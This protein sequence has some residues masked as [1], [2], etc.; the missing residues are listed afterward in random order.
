[1]LGLHLGRSSRQRAYMIS[2]RQ[3]KRNTASKGIRNARHLNASPQEAIRIL[4][5]L[6]IQANNVGINDLL[7]QLFKHVADGEEC[8]S[9]EKAALVL[10]LY[11]RAR[12]K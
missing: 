2:R 11:P 5:G 1:M 8:P 12:Y 3:A 9:T 10:E 7:L 6:E 4:S